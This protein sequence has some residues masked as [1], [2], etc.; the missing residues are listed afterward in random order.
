M[1]KIQ[2]KPY[3]DEEAARRFERIAQRFGMT[4]HALAAVLVHEFSHIR[5]E[6]FFEALGAIPADLKTR[7]VGRPAGST[8]ARKTE[9]EGT[10]AAA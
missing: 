6:A 1:Q 7:P 3:V 5:P 8:S 9:P 2:L 10:H 4:P